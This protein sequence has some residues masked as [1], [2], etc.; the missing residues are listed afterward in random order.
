MAPEF[1]YDKM[2]ILAWQLAALNLH[3]MSRVRLGELKRFTDELGDF[4]KI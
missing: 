4:E 3:T 1:L 2:K